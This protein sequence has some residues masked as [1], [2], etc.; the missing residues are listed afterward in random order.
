MQELGDYLP[1]LPKTTRLVFLESKTLPASHPILKVAKAQ[2]TVGKGHVKLFELPENDQL[3]TWIRERTEDKGGSISHQAI[4]LLAALVG[5]DPRLLDQEI[6]KLLL[7]TDGEPI[8]ADDVRNLVSRVREM[9]IFD[10]VDAVGLRQTDRA[11]K[12]LHLMID[13]LAKPLYLLAML[14]RQIR[15]L[16]QVSELQDQGLSQPEIAKKLKLHPFVV[17]KGLAQARNFNKPQLD[18][19]HQ[20]LVEADW[21]IKTGKMEEV[22]ALDLLVVELSRT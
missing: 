3:P 7:Y 11:L 13:D 4:V 10:L 19:A 2:E 6:D 16:I 12:L 1:A 20:R 22:L 21:S 14:A 5:R 18:A 9:S 17:K 15:I 8:G